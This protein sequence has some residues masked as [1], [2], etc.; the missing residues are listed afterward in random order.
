VRSRLTPQKLSVRA[1][2]VNP[3]ARAFVSQRQTRH[4]LLGSEITW[5]RAAKELI[6]LESGFNKSAVVFSIWYIIA[7]IG[8]QPLV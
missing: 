4:D 3:D 5:G 8:D 2:Q 1:A 7:V 6:R